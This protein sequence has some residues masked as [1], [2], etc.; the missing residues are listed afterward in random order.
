MSANAKLI[1][2]R[3]LMKAKCWSHYIVPLSDAHNSEYVSKRDMRLKF[4][5]G[6]SGSAGTALV[7]LDSACL[8]TDGRY[9]LQAARELE[10][11]WTLMKDRL[12]TTPSIEDYILSSSKGGSEVVVGVDPRLVTVNFVRALKK[13]NIQ[14]DTNETNSENL[15]DAIWGTDQP[16]VPENKVFLHD[17]KYGSP[18]EKIE[19][20]RAEMKKE[21][22]DGLI[23]SSL[24]Q[25]AWLF[26]LRGSDIPFN[27]VFFSY[28]L[29]QL[30]GVALCI[31]EEKLPGDVLEY[32]KSIGV[33]LH[34][35]DAIFSLIESFHGK[36][37]LDGSTS[38]H[39]IYQAATRGVAESDST[40]INARVLEKAS[41]VLLLKAIKN[42]EEIQG[43]HNAHTRDAAALVT[44][45]AWLEIALEK[46]IDMLKNGDKVSFE[47]TEYSVGEVLDELRSK[48]DLFVSLS[49][50]TIV[51]FKENSAVIHYRA[52]KGTAKLIEPGGMLLIDSGAQFTDG[53][54]DVTRTVHTG[55]EPTDEEKHVFTRVLKGHISLATAVFPEKTPGIV[56]DAIARSQLWKSG[57]DYLH[58]TGHGVGHFLNVHEGPFGASP[59]ASAYTGGILAGMTLTDEPGFYAENKFGVRIENVLCAKKANTFF[60]FGEQQYLD[61]ESFTVVPISRK[62]VDKS[63]LTPEEVT[64]FNE[65]NSQCRNKLSPLLQSNE[66]AHKYLIKETEAL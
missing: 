62:L 39:A 18:G 5:C 10:E 54:T 7:S 23:L 1:Q 20:V 3:S 45:L 19:R 35:Y 49:F 31:N 46:G 63:M 53:T 25:I 8:W 11:G 51:G 24:D 12:A 37:W 44:F 22:V 27:P 42:R 65:Y 36:I 41:P 14:V 64:R 48:Q 40:A 30:D 38:S 52:S 29:V 55:G 32:L 17:F 47:L 56:L 2:L 4:I 61:F 15:I 28:A 13:K 6:F 33:S 58:G 16:V 60:S 50:S 21:N 57:L 66:W 26:S 43:F 9:F 59:R 34:P